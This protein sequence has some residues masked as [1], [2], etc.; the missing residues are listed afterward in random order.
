MPEHKRSTAYILHAQSKAVQRLLSRSTAH[1]DPRSLEDH[2]FKLLR[3]L[4]IYANFAGTFHGATLPQNIREGLDAFQDGER[5][6][7]WPS[8]R[9]PQN[10]REAPLPQY[11]TGDIREAPDATEAQL[12]HAADLRFAVRDSRLTAAAAA[13]RDRGLEDDLQDALYVSR[14]DAARR[15]HVARDLARMR[16]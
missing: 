3:H 14:N 1:L 12:R 15:A 7:H 10:I 9:L 2:E 6:R 8:Q 4:R 5:R 13:E 11:I 16:A